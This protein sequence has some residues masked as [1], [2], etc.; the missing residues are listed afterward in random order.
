M[1]ILIYFLFSG[2]ISIAQN[3]DTVKVYFE[4]NQKN[5][6]IEIY[7]YKYRLDNLKIKINTTKS[8]YGYK[9]SFLLTI[10]TLGSGIIRFWIY[11][12]KRYSPFGKWV[13]VVSKYRRNKNLI[14]FYTNDKKLYSTKWETSFIK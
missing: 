14:L 6:I 10:D 5:S 1:S 2:F 12:K 13:E 11:S 9:D 8:E 7:K 3:I 4:T